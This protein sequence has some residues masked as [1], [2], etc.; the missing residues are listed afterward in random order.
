MRKLVFE[1]EGIM[2]IILGLLLILIPNDVI[3]GVLQFI[4][5]F[6]VI[7]FYL[8]V[9]IFH[10]YANFSNYLKIRSLIFTILG[11]VILIL[12]FNFI[13]SIVGTIMLVFLIIDLINSKDKKATFKKDL[14][15][16]IV[17]LVLMVVGVS[18][19]LGIMIIASGIVLIVIGIIKLIAESGLFDKKKKTS[20]NNQTQIKGDFIDV[21]YEKHEE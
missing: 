17:A 7:L 13:G 20:T 5:G 11:F 3:I 4:L 14:I 15:K 12:G 21:E 8:P 10:F 9:T 2:S 16:Y 19:V 6:A 1:I 18:E